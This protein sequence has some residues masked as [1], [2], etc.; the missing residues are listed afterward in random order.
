MITCSRGNCVYLVGAP[1]EPSHI[2]VTAFCLCLDKCLFAGCGVSG[3]VVTDTKQRCLPSRAH[4][5]VWPN[6]DRG[7]AQV[8]C[9]HTGANPLHCVGPVKLSQRSFALIATTG[10]TNW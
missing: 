3:W 1:V 9:P 5:S 2:I 7:Q 6:T 8:V 4:R 10:A